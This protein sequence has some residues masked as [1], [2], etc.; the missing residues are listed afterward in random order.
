M[1]LPW[2]EL[3][4]EASHEIWKKTPDLVVLDVRTAEEYTGP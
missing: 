4:I 2:K 1:P 3:S